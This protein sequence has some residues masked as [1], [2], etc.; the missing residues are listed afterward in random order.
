MTINL[1]GIRLSDVRLSDLRPSALRSVPGAARS[2][3]ERRLTMASTPIVRYYDHSRLAYE[4]QTQMRELRRSTEGEG[5]GE[6]LLQKMQELAPGESKAAPAHKDAVRP[7]AAPEQS[8]TPDS[9]TPVVEPTLNNSGF[10][11]SSL[12][13]QNRPALSGGSRKPMRER[14]T[15]WTA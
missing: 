14:S 12:T 3:L 5:R 8:A 1:T 7:A 6:E 15:V 9:T 11:E 10:L 4:V 2:F 13:F